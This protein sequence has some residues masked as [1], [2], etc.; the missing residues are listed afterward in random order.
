MTAINVPMEIEKIL[1]TYENYE[2]LIKGFYSVETDTENTLNYVIIPRV[3]F[4]RSSSDDWIDGEKW[5][6]KLLCGYGGTGPN[7]LIRFIKEHGNYTKDDLEKKVKQNNVV[8]YDF[9]ANELQAFNSKYN[10]DNFNIEIKAKN[11]GKFVFLPSDKSTYRKKD[12]LQIFDDAIKLSSI[13]FD[14]EIRLKNIKYIGDKK[15][16]EFNYYTSRYFNQ[17]SY[18]NFI[19][20]YNKFEIWLDYPFPLDQKDIQYDTDFKELLKKMNLELSDKKYD[21]PV[22]KIID[23]LMKKEQQK[24]L[25][26]PFVE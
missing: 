15:S 11:D 26:I 7:N 16:E 4:K 8:I 24:N 23:K 14:N 6:S 5:G 9:N 25:T 12:I 13:L 2:P 20:E 3:V 19:L 17:L 22:L 21:N 1:I 18:F 10:R